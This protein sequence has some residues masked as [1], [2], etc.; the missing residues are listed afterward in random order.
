MSLC[1]LLLPAYFLHS[2]LS[3]IPTHHLLPM[4]NP[5]VI[6]SHVIIWL[7]PIHVQALIPFI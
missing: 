6:W 4:F 7:W 2:N 1:Y 5:E 3:H